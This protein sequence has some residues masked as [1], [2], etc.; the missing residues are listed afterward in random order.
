[1]RFNPNPTPALIAMW[2]EEPDAIYGE[3]GYVVLDP[4]QALLPAEVEA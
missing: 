2:P 1:M 4:T 3:D